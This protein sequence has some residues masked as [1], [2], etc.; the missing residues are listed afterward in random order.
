M[1]LRRQSIGEKARKR[2]LE[3][4]RR[5]TLGPLMVRLGYD[6][7]SAVPEWAH[8][9][10]SAREVDHLVGGAAQQLGVDFARAGL[11]PLPDPKSLVREFLGRIQESPVRQKHGGNGFNGALQ[12]YAVALALNPRIIIES[13]VFRGFTTWILR[14]ACP[15]ARIFC[16]DPVLKG[17]RYRDPKATYRTSDWSEF[18]FSG[19]DLSAA[20]ALFDDHI[21][22]ERRI[23]EA[24]ERG[25]RSLLFDDDSPAH[26]I[27]GQ[28]GPAFPTIAMIL[29]AHPEG[30]PVRWLRNGREFV[31][32]SDAGTRAARAR[33]AVAQRFEDMHRITGYSPARLTYVRLSD[34]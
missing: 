11:D 29:A 10:L 16:F 27:H 33:I 12:I 15:E 6:L 2:L 32:R 26:C 24:A 31:W 22:Q 13:G 17:L 7:T 9:P 30:E 19:L 4:L 8:R 3:P 34:A 25:L 18:D 20:P 23:H 21:S 1:D 14:Q 5:H 28:G